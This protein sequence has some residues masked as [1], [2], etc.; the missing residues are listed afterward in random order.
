[1]NPAVSAP[2]ALFESWLAVLL[3]PVAWASALGIL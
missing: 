2:R 3:A 1:M